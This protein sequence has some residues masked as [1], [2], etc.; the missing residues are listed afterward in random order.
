MFEK[1]SKQLTLALIGLI[2]L[3]LLC[4]VSNVSGTNLLGWVEG[5]HDPTTTTQ[6]LYCPGQHPK[7][8]CKSI[9]KCPGSSGLGL[10]E[11]DAEIVDRYIYLKS[12]LESTKLFDTKENKWELI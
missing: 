8:P 10:S 11:E 9:K 4:Q 1:Y 2:L 6:P 3:I 7:V 5:Y 12:L